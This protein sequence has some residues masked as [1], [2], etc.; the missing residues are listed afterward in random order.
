MSLKT[1]ACTTMLLDYQQPYPYDL[2]VA[3]LRLRGIEGV[4]SVGEDGVYRRIAHIGANSGWLCVRNVPRE[5]A[6]ELTVSASLASDIEHVGEKVRRLFDT[7]CNPADVEAGLTDFYSRVSIANHIPGIRVP[8]SFDGFEMFVRAVLGQQITVKA[9]STLAGRVAASFGDPYPASSHNPMPPFSELTTV[10]PSP[11]AF[12][13]ENAASRLGE[14]GVINLRAQA[15]C[16]VAS[17]IVEGKLDLSPC[18]NV[19]ETMKTLLDVKGIGP[20]TAHYVAMRALAFPDAFPAED[21]GVKSAFPNM[22]PRDLR[23]LSAAW[24]PYR[25]Y[26]VMSLWQAP[27]R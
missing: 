26:A 11:S 10:F 12:C 18:S 16:E 14:L 27:H 17:R 21:Y 8:C 9:A 3:F 13:A 7:G 19:D 25:S 24:S 2:L 23:K 20:W 15:I 1:D 22:K 6:I 5:N 4:E